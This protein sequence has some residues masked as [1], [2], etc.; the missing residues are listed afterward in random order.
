MEKIKNIN[1][2]NIHIDEAELK[3]LNESRISKC[4]TIGEL[5]QPKAN[6]K[7]MRSLNK[8]FKKKNTTK[9]NSC[10]LPTK[11]LNKGKIIFTNM[12]RND[13]KNNDLPLMI[14][15]KNNCPS[16]NLES[17]DAIKIKKKIFTDGIEVNAKYL[18]TRE[19]KDGLNSGIIPVQSSIITKS[20]SFSAEQSEEKTNIISNKIFVEDNSIINSYNTNPKSSSL[21]NLGNSSSLNIEFLKNNHNKLLN[22]TLDI[23]ENKMFNKKNKS[24]GNDIINKNIYFN[25]ENNSLVIKKSIFLNQKKK[26]GK[27]FLN[28]ILH[29]DQRLRRD[30]TEKLENLLTCNRSYNNLSNSTNS[31]D[32][33]ITTDAFKNKVSLGDQLISSN[34][35]EFNSNYSILSNNPEIEKRKENLHQQNFLDFPITKKECIDMLEQIRRIVFNIENM[36]IVLLKTKKY[37]GEYEFDYNV[38]KKR[39]KYREVLEC[40]D[41]PWDLIKVRNM[42]KCEILQLYTQLINDERSYNSLILKKCSSKIG[43]DINKGNFQ[44]FIK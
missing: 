7:K 42:K 26:K 25:E 12:L 21:F 10:F 30:G 40:K 19:T 38:K 22:K 39:I 6:I 27:P 1:K 37:P 34:Q 31:N 11:N 44:I 41:F 24:F 8:I 16:R 14:P 33:E 35:F 13:N 3:K 20:L 43:E 32:K 9:L 36:N 15:R 2:A 5:K 29:P 18:N 28:K 4:N 23:K 17:Y